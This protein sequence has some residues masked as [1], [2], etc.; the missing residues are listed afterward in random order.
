MAHAAVSAPDGHRHAERLARGGIGQAGVSAEPYRAFMDEWVIEGPSFSDIRIFAQGADFAYNIT[1]YSDLPFVPQGADGFSVKS[2][3][4]QASHYYSQ[5]F[6]KVEGTLTFPDR[7]I[8]V[9]GQAGLD[10]ECP[11]HP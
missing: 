8:A 9:T 4:G 11:R 10:R 3:A 6:Y 2:K 1:A 5:P 7:T